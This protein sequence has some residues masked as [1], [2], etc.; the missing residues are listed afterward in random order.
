MLLLL[1]YQYYV[2]GE[3]L[4]IFIYQCRSISREDLLVGLKCDLISLL[5][6]GVLNLSH[7]DEEN[8]LNSSLN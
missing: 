3:N 6:F 8:C 4:P 5:Y 2:L 7:L 1:L